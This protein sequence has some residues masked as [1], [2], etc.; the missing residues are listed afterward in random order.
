MSNKTNKLLTAAVVLQA[1]T[2]AGQWFNPTYTSTAQAQVPDAGAQRLQQIEQLKEINAKL[3]RI[4][5]VLEGGKLQVRVARED[6]K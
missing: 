5:G 6:A 3:D 4:G 1:L 2:L